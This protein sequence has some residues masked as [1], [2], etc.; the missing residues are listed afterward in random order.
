MATK[1]WTGVVSGDFSV[2]GNFTGG[3]PSNNDTVYISGSVSISSG[4]STGLTGINLIVDPGYTG[5]IGLIGTYFSMACATFTYSGGGLSYI[6]LGSS[7]IAAVVIA[8]AAASSPSTSGLYLKGSNLLSLLVSGGYVALAGQDSETSTV[9]TARVSGSTANLVLGSGVTLT[10]ASLS[11][12]NLVVNCA[13]TT[14]NVN[15]GILTTGGSGAI[16]TVNQYAG[17]SYPYSTGTITTHNV[18]GGTASY[19]G[20]P[21]ART[22]TTLKLN[23]GGIAI[24]DSAI[25]TVTNK[26]TYDSPV[27]LVASAP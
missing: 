9:A 23:P 13:A 16:T 7:N 15:S 27:K 1:I 17:T 14:I 3:S 10:T 4:L 25:V 11:S 18:L 22:V 20:F 8:T 19:I 12:G 21:V 6:D 5:S 2:T 24:Y 26:I